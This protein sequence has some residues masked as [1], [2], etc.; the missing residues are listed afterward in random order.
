LA[1]LVTAGHKPGH[2]V[3]SWARRRAR[4]AS[5]RPRYNGGMESQV[6]RYTREKISAGTLRRA[7]LR[8][9]QQQQPPLPERCDN[10]DCPFHTGPLVW[11]GQPL[12]LTLDHANGVNSDNRPKNLRLL[13]PNCDSQLATRGGGNKGRVEKGYGGFVKIEG[14][15]RFYTLF[16]VKSGTAGN[17]PIGEYDISSVEFDNN[18]IV[19]GGEI[20]VHCNDGSKLPV[21]RIED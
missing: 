10:P 4:A 18:I 20:R 17:F 13:C 6:L 9:R 16:P 11:N 7:C 19:S 12:K 2:L 1:V 21:C 14:D 8:W 15:D 5:N 3:A